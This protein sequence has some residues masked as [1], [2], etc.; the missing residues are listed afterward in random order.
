[1]WRR[2]K[3]KVPVIGLVFR[4]DERKVPVTVLFLY[5]TMAASA[6]QQLASMEQI[7][8][9]AAEL[10]E[11]SRQLKDALGQFVLRVH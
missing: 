5:E 7:E 2:L 11:M 1:M 3:I 9:S 6:E 4:S 10:K 8:N